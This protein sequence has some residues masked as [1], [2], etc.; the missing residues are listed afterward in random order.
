MSGLPFW[1]PPLNKL[2]LLK[3][4]MMTQI[5]HTGTYQFFSS[6]G[7]KSAAMQMTLPVPTSTLSV[8]KPPKFSTLSWSNVTSNFITPSSVV[9]M[10]IFDYVIMFSKS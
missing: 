2:V 4:R 7:N 10:I 3:N 5:N 6:I 1:Q 8:S 9:Y